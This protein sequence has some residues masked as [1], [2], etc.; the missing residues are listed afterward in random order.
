MLARKYWLGEAKAVKKITKL[1]SIQRKED[2]GRHGKYT[3]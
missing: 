3:S 1:S 2:K